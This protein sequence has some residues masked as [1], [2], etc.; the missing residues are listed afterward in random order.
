MRYPPDHRFSA[1]QKSLEDN[2]PPS[3]SDVRELELYNL[4]K[5]VVPAGDTPVSKALDINQKNYKREVMESFLLAGATSKEIED[6]IGVM[7]EVTE[8]YTHLFFDTSVFE[9]RLD[10][11][12]Y[13]NTYN[14]SEYGSQ[15]KKVAVDFG[16]DALRIRMTA[17]TSYVSPRTVQNEIRA[18]AYMLAQRAKTNPVDSD[19]ARE[20]RNWA[21][22]AL[23][24][25]ESVE[26]EVTSG[27]EELS[28]ALDARDEA[29]NE[30]TSG[31]PAEEILH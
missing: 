17:A 19:V 11:I 8:A 3:S 22:L 21:V 4:F 5:E 30:D 9:D 7:S 13:A 29:T 16:K 12:E 1:V 27:I 18:V 25:A 20:A 15:L 26:E 31:I 2:N 23:R 28:I 14:R 6:A 10:K 24:A